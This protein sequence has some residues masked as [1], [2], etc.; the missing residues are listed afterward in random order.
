MRFSDNLVL[1][2]EAAF[3]GNRAR[4]N[5]RVL[6]TQGSLESHASTEL[7]EDYRRFYVAHPESHPGLTADEAVKELFKDD[8]GYDKIGASRE[9]VDRLKQH[10]VKASFVEFDGEEHMS[11]AI[12]ALNRGVPFA[13]RPAH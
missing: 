5:V 1:K 13:L 10:G 11:A 3:E 8:A 9:L 7:V 4:E 2:E 6:V 12:S